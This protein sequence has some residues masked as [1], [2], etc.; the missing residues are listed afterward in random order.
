MYR[1]TAIKLGIEA[2]GR[3]KKEYAFDCNLYRRETS[4]QEG[5]KNRGSYQTIGGNAMKRKILGGTP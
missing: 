4:G 5:G 3:W 1:K 2:L